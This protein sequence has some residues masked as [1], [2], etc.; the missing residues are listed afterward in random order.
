M[1]KT[2]KDDL[3]KILGKRPFDKKEKEAETKEEA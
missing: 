2:L 3:V 1:E